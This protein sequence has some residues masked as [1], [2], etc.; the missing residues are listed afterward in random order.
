[1]FSQILHDQ[2]GFKWQ[3]AVFE[4]NSSSGLLK[5]TY[6][7]RGLSVI[8]RRSWNVIAT[9]NSGIIYLGYFHFIRIFISLLI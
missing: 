8:F 3:V 4:N 6:D 9:F 5:K 7:D 2:G 1:M